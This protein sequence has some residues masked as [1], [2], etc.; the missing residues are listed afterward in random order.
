MKW[1]SATAVFTAALPSLLALGETSVTL[2]QNKTGLSVTD[3]TNNF[4]QVTDPAGTIYTIDGDVTL[5]NYNSI[6]PTPPSPPAEEG[7]AESTASSASLSEINSPKKQTQQAPSVDSSSTTTKTAN[8]ESKKYTQ[9]GA[10]YNP[11][12]FAPTSIV[13]NPGT[14]GSLTISKII[15]PEEGGGIYSKGPLTIEGLEN[16][17]FTGNSSQT[18][19]GAIFCESTTTIADIIDTITFSNNSA[20]VPSPPEEQQVAE[21]TEAGTPRGNGG[22]I[23]S[24]GKLLIEDFGSMNLNKNSASG[25]GGAFYSDSAIEISRSTGSTFANENTAKENGGVLSSISTITLHD[26]D[27]A[28]F[29]SNKAEKKGGAIYSGGAF[30]ISGDKGSS[31][32]F[33]SANKANQE[34]GGVYANTTTD[35]FD[36]S[37]IKFLANTAGVEPPPSEEEDQKELTSVDKS[38][39]SSHLLLDVPTEESGNGGGLYSKENVTIDGVLS[40]VLFQGNS[41]VTGNGGGA[42]AAKSFSCQNSRRL[43][44]SNNTA[45]KNGGGLYSKEDISWS[46]L[47]G[48]TL[49][50]ANKAGEKGGGIYVEN[51]HSVSLTNLEKLELTG[52]QASSGGA[53]YAPGGFSITFE[54]E[55]ATILPE[56]PPYAPK[57]DISAFGDVIISS[58]K[59]TKVQN[60]PE[61]LLVTAAS[62]Q[63]EENNGGGIYSKKVSF[64]NLNSVSISGNSAEKGG[65]I[66]SS[67]TNANGIHALLEKGQKTNKL[68]ATLLLSSSEGLKESDVF[69]DYIGSVSL[70]SNSATESGGGIYGKKISFCRI[71]ELSFLGN[72]AQTSGGAIYSTENLNI[73]NV[74]NISASNNKGFQSGGAI[75][76]KNFSLDSCRSITF[77]KN[78][79]VITKPAA[80]IFSVEENPAGGGAIYGE[81]VS[82]TSTSEGSISFSDNSAI[83]KTASTQISSNINTSSTIAYGGGVSAK[84]SIKLKGRSSF[85]SNSAD[86]GGAL[87]SLGTISIEGSSNFSGNSATSESGGAIYAG[88]TLTLAGGATFSGNTSAKDGSAIYLKAPSSSNGE[89]SI[90]ATSTILF[91]DNVVAPSTMKRSRVYARD[92]SLSGAAIFGENGTSSTTPKLDLTAETGDIIFRNNAVGS[93]E[94]NSTFCSI[95]GKI[96]LNLYADKGTIYFYDAVNTTGSSA[97][98]CKINKNNGTSYT[99]KVVFSGKEHANKSTIGQKVTLSS[100]SLILDN[101]ELT[102]NSFTQEGGTLVMNA[103]SALIAKKPDTVLHTLSSEKQASKTTPVNL[104]TL[105]ADSKLAQPRSAGENGITITNLLI[106]I[107]GLIGGDGK[108]APKIN[109]ADGN[110]DSSVDLSQA[111]ITIIDPNGD[112]YQNPALGKDLDLKLINL[113]EEQDNIS[114]IKLYGDITPL[115]GYMGTWKLETSENNSITAKWTFDRYQQWAYVPRESS[116]YLNSLVGAR[117]SLVAVKQ[118]IL[119]NCLSSARFDDPLYNVVWTSG[120]GTFLQIEEHAGAAAL[121]YNSKGYIAALD[122]KPNPDLILGAAF[123]QMFGRTKTEKMHKDYDYYNSEH[124]YQTTFYAGCP[125]FLLS[126][127]YRNKRPVL[128]Q[129]ILSYAYMKHRSRTFYP[130]IWE[131]NLADWHDRAWVLDSRLTFDFREPTVDSSARLSAFL[132]C[133]CLSLRQSSFEESYYNPRKFDSTSYRYVALP[134]GFSMEGTLLFEYALLYNKMMLAYTPSIFRNEPMAQYIVLSEGTKGVIRGNVPPRNTARIEFHNNT[135]FAPCWSLYGSYT[136]EAGENSFVQM[137]NLG[138]RMV[139]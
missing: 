73:D 101:A 135:Q 105:Q 61:D 32:V 3:S 80:A 138:S 51:D 30:V 107:S 63:T 95:G 14:P 77:S 87:A 64:S 54:K 104:K 7:A 78:S 65:G 28:K 43:Q 109:L 2:N 131:K 37:E 11:Y 53:I 121:N 10:F 125:V 25:S 70:S 9:G 5:S 122:S 12:D 72:T 139:F 39:P 100:G 90:K 123:S 83:T 34:G 41:A 127:N 31:S 85:S 18:E 62:Q 23:S 106:D 91:C 20:I 129:G 111:S 35:F 114:N 136:M 8:S 134:V 99:G 47:S 15:V 57:P 52:N 1:L 59:A 96:D 17:T 120:V 128:W 103:G 92:D 60:P 33:F 24:K 55:S 13:T 112:L 93:V 86:A 68:K 46:N 76:A 4:T 137:L 16:L 130:S 69:F 133:E 124:S 74:T 29:S 81:T 82:I 48:T 115:K 6:P 38:T 126:K 84:T 49:F 19:G 118:G 71:N 66:F 79:L 98:T 58:N 56:T 88:G 113:P 40:T 36:V 117:A 26:L 75:Y 22:A 42:Y 45:T 97:S 27:S 108:K 50:N 132:G 102:V 119:N 110:N 116:Y 44:F 89:S 94:K 21:Q 67:A